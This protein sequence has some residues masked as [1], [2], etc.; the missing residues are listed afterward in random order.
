MVVLA[1][2]L[3]LVLALI[4]AAFYSY[5]DRKSPIDAVPIILAP[6]PKA[7]GVYAPNTLLQSVEKL[8]TGKLLQPEDI[9][10]DPSGKFL[11]VSTSDG[12]IKKLYLA[13]GSVEDW[14]HVGGRPLGLAV[15]NDGEVLV[16]E[17]STGLLK[18]TD[19]GVEV[20]VTEVE[21]TKLNFVDAVAVAKDG[22]IY[23]TDAST[24]YPLD[25][26]VLDNLESRPHGR[27]LVYNP[28]DKTSRILRK[29]LYMANGIT[30]S[31]DD[32]YLVFAETVAARIS[33]YY[34]KGNKK[35]SIEIINENLPG[36]PDN[37]HY[38]SERELLYIGI[39]GQRDA[40][41]DV[42]L[43]T[44]WLKKFVALYESVR[45]AVDN[46][47]KMGRVLVIDNNGTPVKSYQDPT[48][49]VVGFTTGGVEVDGYV[50]VGGLRDDYVGRVKL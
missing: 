16:C 20:L 28:E 30:L 1:S 48:G 17:P 24:K 29:D 22:L 37:V 10:V 26:F 12:W 41:L 32:E 25:D 50:Y 11:Y 18:V 15:G 4:A 33:K 27:L 34:L 14:K 35:G 40:A 45:G 38:D 39:V 47:N 44:P 3:V 8:G 42:F 31:K 5:V 49:K 21:G 19:E 36:F 13:D 7:E 46:S 6:F 2:V 9:I 43:K 23:F